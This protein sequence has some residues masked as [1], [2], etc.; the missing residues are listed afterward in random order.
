MSL[1]LIG[2]NDP[3]YQIKQEW[4][5]KLERKSDSKRTRRVAE[6]SLS[7]F[8][9]FAEHQ[10]KTESEVIKE[11]QESIND[12]EKICLGIDKFVKF[13]NEDHDD[14][15]Q[16]E[17]HRWI[18]FNPNE[19]QDKPPKLWKKKHP[20]TIKIYFSFIKSYLRICHHLRVSTDDIKDYVTFPK[21]RKEA[22]KPVSVEVWQKVFDQ[23]S[24]LRRALYY[25]LIS[26][27]MRIGEA[28]ALKKSNFHFDENPVRVEIDAEVTK[29]KEERETYVSSEAVRKIKQ[30]LEGKNENELLFTH[31]KEENFDSLNEFDKY[32]FD[33]ATL[34]DDD[35]DDA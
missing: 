8:K 28:L 30:I 22:R 34:L 24:P 13:L 11:Y 16:D 6:V 21:Q 23:A 18:I 1:Q 5:D 17:D 4:L 15:K 10:D 3:F 9:L 25:T 2:K 33:A 26:S 12:I 31:M 35:E 14:I 29:T 32:V 20:K 7:M 27:G 19:I